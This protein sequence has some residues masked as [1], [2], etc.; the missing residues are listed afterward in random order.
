M[1]LED[2]KIIA[3]AILVVTGVVIAVVW[4]IACWFLWRHG[5]SSRIGNLPVVPHRPSREDMKTAGHIG[6][7]PVGVTKPEPP[8]PPPPKRIPGSVPNI[9]K[10]PPIPPRKTKDRRNMMA[11]S[12]TRKRNVAELHA[13]VA[14]H[15]EELIS[16][17]GFYDVLSQRLTE[18]SKREDE[19][20]DAD[21]KR[22]ETMERAFEKN[23]K[24][25]QGVISHYDDHNKKTYQRQRPWFDGMVFISFALATGTFIGSLLLYYL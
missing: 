12:K 8:P 21:D 10:V 20:S 23:L 2:G 25:L 11:D 7:P 4:G 19:R 16:L 9:P 15:S 13:L 1:N 24:N 17:A 6:N 3:I 14:E 18:A 22:W 5:P